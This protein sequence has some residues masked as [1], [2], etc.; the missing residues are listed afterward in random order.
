MNLTISLLT[1]LS[2]ALCRQALIC[3]LVLNAF[4]GE[5]GAMH[6]PLL[7]LFAQMSSS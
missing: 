2:Y 7:L 3:W 5:F 1:R 6:L 4:A